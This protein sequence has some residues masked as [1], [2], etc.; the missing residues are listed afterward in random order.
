MRRYHLALAM[1]FAA[2]AAETYGEQS[3]PNASRLS[4]VHPLRSVQCS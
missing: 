2:G 3:A 1:L 4:D